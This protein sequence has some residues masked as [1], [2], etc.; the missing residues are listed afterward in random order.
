MMRSWRLDE[1]AAP[2][3]GHRVGNNVVV[4]GVSTDS[5]SIGGEALFI[6]LT[7]E[8]FDG[9]DFIEQA[10]AGGAAAAVVSRDVQAPLP[11]L[12]VGD[13]QRALGDI[14]RLNRQAFKGPL[15]AITGS[16]GKTS[17]KNMLKE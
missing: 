15:V 3:Q 1:L 13:T 10:A 9:H 12:R 16:T 2:L 7:G 4:N 5:R 14:G 6:A 11:V 8:R 17:V